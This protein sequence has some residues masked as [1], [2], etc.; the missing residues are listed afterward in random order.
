MVSCRKEYQEDAELRV[1][2]MIKQNSQMASGQIA[3]KV[4]ILNG[5]A[6]YL[7]TSLIDMGDFKLNSFKEN[8]QKAKNYYLVTLKV[9]REKSLLTSQFLVQKKQ[10]LRL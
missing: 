4:G 7:L 10:S 8:S 3:R 2:Q 6:Y 5:F 9:I 1:M